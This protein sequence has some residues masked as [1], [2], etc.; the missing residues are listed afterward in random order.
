MLKRP[1]GPTGPRAETSEGFTL[2]EVTVALVLLAVA[3]LGVNLTTGR[4][5]RT[6]AE[7]EVRAV[8]QQAVEDRLT[9]IRM[10]PRYP[11][12]DSLYAGT[13]APVLGLDGFSRATTFQ[14]VDRQLPSGRTLDYWTVWVTVEGPFV[15]SPMSR[16]ITVGQP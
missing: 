12:L 14:R 7:E 3:F 9:E 10:D 6:V 13:E 11:V 2:I 16:T 1:L 8:V 5:V 4:M 15:G